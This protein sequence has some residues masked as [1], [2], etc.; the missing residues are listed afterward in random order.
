MAGGIFPGY[1]FTLNIKC[2]IFS[3]VVMIAFSICPRGLSQP[4]L[5]TSYFLIFVLSY[6]A[7]AWYDYYY[8]C[9]TLPLQRSSV[10]I[11][12]AFKPPAHSPER[13]E[14]HL[15]SQDEVDKNMWTIY[16]L[17]IIVIVPL[18]TYIGFKGATANPMSYS[19]LLA[20]AA[21]TA[22]YHGFRLMLGS[23]GGLAAPT[24]QANGGPGHPH[25]P[26]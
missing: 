25:G 26:S 3:L 13:Q 6:V 17:H 5:L 11:T 19:L 14:G 7:M 24:G 4:A 22:I 18:I 21:F 12:G 1:P 23:H 15:M 10:G 20:L 8:N 9:Q 2:I 16:L